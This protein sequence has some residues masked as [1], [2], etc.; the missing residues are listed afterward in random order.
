MFRHG[1]GLGD[2]GTKEPETR[3]KGR[4]YP[5]GRRFRRVA[6]TIAGF[7]GSL[8][9]MVGARAIHMAAHSAYRKLETW[10]YSMTFVEHCYRVTQRFP[11]EEMYGLTSQLR[12]AAVSIP[13]NVAEGYCR[14][15]TKVYAN[16]VSIALGSHGELETCTELA[17]RLGFLTKADYSDLEAQLGSIGRLLNALHQSL[18]ERIRLEEAERRRS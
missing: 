12:R 3:A 16:H 11:R 15:S 17:L 14:R 1:R 9:G 10:Q 5:T 6:A 13:S 18:E 7:S 8:H 4:I 2:S